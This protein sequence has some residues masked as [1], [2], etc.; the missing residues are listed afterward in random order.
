MTLLCEKQNPT[1]Y[2]EYDPEG[3]MTPS[4]SAVNIYV[5]SGETIPQSPS[6]MVDAAFDDVCTLEPEDWGM[7]FDFILSSGTWTTPRSIVGVWD[8][9]SSSAYL[10]A[11][12]MLAT[13]NQLAFALTTIGHGANWSGLY[14]KDTTYTLKLY[15]YSEAP[16]F[17]AKLEI[18]DG[19]TL[20][21]TISGYTTGYGDPVTADMR[22][23]FAEFAGQV[24]GD[25]WDETISDLWLPV[26]PPVLPMIR[27]HGTL[28]EKRILEGGNF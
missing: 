1:E 22:V 6:R 28:G 13:Y 16:L 11:T 2:T 14:A 24:N 20:Q 8:T 19:G 26:R 5:P 15:S 12:M 18:Y 7:Q 25:D 23:R 4:A 27:K 21:E 9:S 17:H 10:T 3:V